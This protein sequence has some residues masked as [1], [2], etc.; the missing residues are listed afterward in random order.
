MRVVVTEKPS[1]ARDL[2]RV[3]G[4]TNR[5]KGWLEGNDLAITWCFGHMTELEE[6]AHYNPDWKRW[7]LESLPMIPDRFSLRVR[8]GAKGTVGYPQKIALFF[9]SYFG[10]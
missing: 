5:R 8:K 1:V 6:P 9:Q 4:A 7:R 10:S 3:L 2:A